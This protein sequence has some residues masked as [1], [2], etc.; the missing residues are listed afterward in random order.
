MIPNGGRR[1]PEAVVEVLI[2]L[3]RQLEAREP[4]LIACGVYLIDPASESQ[5][6]RFRALQPEGAWEEVAAADGGE[7][8]VRTWRA[9]DVVYRQNL[10]GEDRE[11]DNHMES[12]V[13]PLARSV[14]EVPFSHGVLAIASAEPAAFSPPDIEDAGRL[15]GILSA[16][17]HRLEEQ[18]LKE[19]Q[20][21]QAQKL[22]LIGQLAAG[23]V[24]DLNNA[25]TVI[26]GQCELM[27]AEGPDSATRES[28]AIISRA[29]ET[30]LSL[31][32]LLLGV[33]RGQEVAKKRFDLNQ[34]VHEIVQLLYRQFERK[35]VTLIEE[36][37]ADLP[38]VEVHAG[39]LQ[40]LLLN[41]LQNSRDAI[42]SRRE[43]GVV[44]V[45]TTAAVG[46]VKLEVE[47]DGPG[48]PEA[49]RDRIF[50]PFFTTKEKGK[51]TGLGL[52][53]CRSIAR[54]HGGRLRLTPRSVG[55]CMVLE[56]PAAC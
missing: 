14:L 40:Q 33:A 32:D 53:V 23:T 1:L 27:L 10:E 54:E 2:S 56:L 28:A 19:E 35:K 34:L 29:A 41:L 18:E 30:T 16:L 15:S 48:I 25:L 9:G 50:D 42:L 44:R 55:T 4:S 51:G 31:T 26:M 8:V 21:R 7:A 37:Q 47:D 13:A 17:C 6:V 46:W 43:G 20:L 52:S 24:H 11:E 12:W 36:L 5:R 39:Q 45:K 38:R 3:G 22:A 49:L